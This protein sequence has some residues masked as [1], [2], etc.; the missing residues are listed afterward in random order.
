LSMD[1]H[2]I[3]DSP[4]TQYSLLRAAVAAAVA[5]RQPRCEVRSLNI[6]YS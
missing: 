3:C 4:I 5:G 2:S 1:C 6:C